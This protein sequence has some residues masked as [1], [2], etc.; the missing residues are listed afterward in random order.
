MTRVHPS[1][2]AQKRYPFLTKSLG[3]NFLIHRPSAR[4][5]QRRSSKH[6]PRTILEIGR[7]PAR[8]SVAR[9][10]KRMILVEKDAQFQTL[11]EE[12]VAPPGPR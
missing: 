10:V 2:R 4:P 12:V 3:Q 6:A 5:S 11:L 7:A 9:P 8:S 1:Y